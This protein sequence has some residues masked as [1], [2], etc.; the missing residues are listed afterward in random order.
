MQKKLVSAYREYWKGSYWE[1]IAF[2]SI[3]AGMTAGRT[4]L[5]ILKQTW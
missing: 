4:F 3:F 2:L 1:Q 5:I